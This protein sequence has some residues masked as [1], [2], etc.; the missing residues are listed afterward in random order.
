MRYDEADLIGF[1]GVSPL[2]CLQEEREFFGSCEFVVT[3][4]PMRLDVSFS[5]SHEPMVI[6]ELF[7]GDDE[8]AVARVNVARAEKVR[9][10][11]RPKRLVVLT[12]PPGSGSVD[13][14]LEETL[15]IRLDP[16]AIVLNR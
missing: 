1:F 3:R 11:A 15:V 4:G 6:A 7:V 13:P 10:E 2:E 12:A 5:S 8:H 16:L 14:S 9:V